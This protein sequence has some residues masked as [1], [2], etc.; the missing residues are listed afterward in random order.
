MV[1][2]R[3]SRAREKT[4]AGSANGSANG[5]AEK[6][7][8]ATSTTKASVETAKQQTIIAKPAG[9]SNA[10]RFALLLVCVAGIYAAYLKQGLLQEQL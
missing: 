7:S 6:R 1:A 8:G 3:S 9:G 10:S 2:T 4:G 5:D